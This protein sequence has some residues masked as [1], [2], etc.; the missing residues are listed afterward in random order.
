[1]FN[2]LSACTVMVILGAFAAITLGCGGERPS[3]PSQPSTSATL[4]VTAIS[5]NTGSSSGTALVRI[6]GAGFQSGAT[7]TVG[8]AGIEAT[9]VTPWML[10]VSMPPHAG[11]MVDVV[12]TNPGG[13]SLKVPGGY[14]YVVT[15]L[16]VSEVLP[17]AGSTGG[18][19]TLKIMG[20]GLHPGAIVKVDGIV[21]PAWSDGGRTFISV[22]TLA[23]TAGSVDI[24]VTNPDGQTQ[25]LAYTYA[26]ADSFDFNGDWVGWVWTD[27][28]SDAG[29]VIRFTVRNNVL[30]SVFS[31]GAL[32]LTVSPPTVSNGQFAYAGSGGGITGRILSASQAT[33]TINTAPSPGYFWNATRQ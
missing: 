20:T 23:H 4:S 9:F 31:D 25:G 21:R 7:V 30:V 19:T 2:N 5:P 26:S 17:N 24:V 29:M 15:P 8:G 6:T 13:Q 32:D 27:P 28:N 11:G 10:T 22:T 14:I 16:V 18:G 12:V 3:T 1:M 33:G